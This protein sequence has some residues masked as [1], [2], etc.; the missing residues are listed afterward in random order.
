MDFNLLKN[1]GSYKI[2]FHAKF[3][4]RGTNTQYSNQLLYS[5]TTIIPEVALALKF[6]H[7]EAYMV[8]WEHMKQYF[9]PSQGA[10]A[11]HHAHYWSKLGVLR[12]IISKKFPDCHFAA[13]QPLSKS[14]GGYAN[15]TIGTVSCC[16]RSAFKSDIRLQL[17]FRML[18]IIPSPL[19]RE[20]IRDIESMHWPLQLAVLDQK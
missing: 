20:G 9:N 8:A 12:H 7:Q 14:S 18:I 2:W 11:P 5:A 1:W 19:V 4:D 6:W 10:I 17:L 3:A 16:Y 15:S 13:A